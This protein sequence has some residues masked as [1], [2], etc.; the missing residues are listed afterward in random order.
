M[1]RLG[2]VLESLDCSLSDFHTAARMNPLRNESLRDFMM[3]D[4]TEDHEED[5]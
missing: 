1:L 2:Y 4:L 3:D 5:I